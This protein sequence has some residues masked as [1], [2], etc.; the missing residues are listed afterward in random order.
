MVDGLIIPD[1]VQTLDGDGGV[2]KS[3]AMM[4]VSVAVPAGKPIFERETSQRPVWFITDEDVED[5]IQPVMMAMAAELDVNLADLPLEVSSLLDFDIAIADIDDNGKVKLLAFHHFL[6]TMLAERRGYLVVL[7]CLND[8]AQMPEAGR[9]APNAFFK[10]VM[11]PL[12][13]K[14]G[15]TMMVLAHPS[16]AAMISGA[17]Y[18]GSTGYKTAVRHKLVMKLVDPKDI[19]GPRTL[20]TLKKNWGKRSPPI[21]LSWQRG[22]FILDRDDATG[23]VKY[24]TVVRKILE[25]IEDGGRVARSNQAD[26]TTPKTLAADILDTEGAK[27]TTAKDV[28]AFMRRAEAEGVLKYVEATNHHEKAH[29]ERG[30]NAGDFGATDDDFSGD[31]ADMDPDASID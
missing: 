28:S 5:D 29:F 15:V 27:L 1:I 8:I 22:I 24:R 11:T 23:A 7:D 20:E 30:D 4:Q 18:S 6:D 17:W 16:K 25:V 14:H 2:G 3:T 12:C 19:Y 13:K 21:T 10:K 9:A 26:C 31:P